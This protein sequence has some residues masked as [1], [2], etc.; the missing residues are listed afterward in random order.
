GEQLQV[1]PSV[2]ELFRRL[3]D[4]S[5]VNQYGPTEAHVVSA[6]T[7]EGPPSRWPTLPPIGRPIANARIYLLDP[8]LDPVPPGVA[9]EL[10]LGGVSL[11]R[12]YL[13]RPEMSAEKF[14][15]HP[16][17]SEGGSRLYKTGDLGRYLPDGQIEYLGRLDHQVKIRGFRVEIGE[18]EV[19]LSGHLAISECAVIVREDVPGDK[20]LVAYSVTS[21]E[22]PPSAGD[23]RGFLKGRLPEYMVPSAFVFLDSLPLTRTGKVD[24][25]ALPASNVTLPEAGAASVQPRTP[26]EELLAQ[27]WV[28][29]L[30]VKNIGIYDNFFELGGD[31]ILTIQVVARANRAGLRLVPKQLFEHQTIAG[32]AAVA[33]TTISVQAEQSAVSG[34]VPL[35]PI[36]HWFFDQNIPNPDH[37]NMGYLFE[38]RADEAPVPSLVEQTLRILLSHHDA[39]RLRFVYGD[40]GWNQANAPVEEAAFFSHHDLSAYSHAHQMRTIEKTGTTLQSSLSLTDGP[41]V[42]AALFDLGKERAHRLLIIIHHA[43]VDGVSWRILVEDFQN[44][45]HRLQKGEA[46]SLPPKTTSFQQWAERLNEH[47][48]SGTITQEAT[49]WLAQSRHSF[50]LLPMDKPDGVNLES[51]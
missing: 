33:G 50:V 18:I 12:C 11:A 10:Y 15:P 7:L 16:F 36:Q 51:S 25:L 42:R 3:P 4:C 19:A 39:L 40:G 20:R 1:T 24:R 32:L 2:V 35:T 23:L 38:W 46:A 5:L 9:G 8:N 45:Y 30:G 44:V 14:V 13:N 48:Q 34:P 31:S 29:V 22:Q 37:F 27:I 21:H 41:L 6:F 17:D 47:A 49:Y 43:A 26:V 28:E